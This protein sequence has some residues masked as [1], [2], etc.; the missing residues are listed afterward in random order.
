MELQ[1]FELLKLSS[2]ASL[3]LMT[4]GVFNSLDFSFVSWCSHVV[5]VVPPKR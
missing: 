4:G 2:D 1:I 5:T 3:V